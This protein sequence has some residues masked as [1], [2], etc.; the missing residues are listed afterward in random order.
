[1]RTSARICNRFLSFPCLPS[2]LQGKDGKAIRDTCFFIEAFLRTYRD[3]MQQFC[4]AENTLCRCVLIKE[5]WEFIMRTAGTNS[6]E[7]GC[8]NP[9][10]ALCGLQKENPLCRCGGADSVHF[11][12]RRTVPE[13]TLNRRLRTAP[14]LSAPSQRFRLHRPGLRERV[15][16]ALSIKTLDLPGFVPPGTSSGKQE[17]A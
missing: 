1:M 7:P 8:S 5:E 11:W 16:G 17:I 9:D 15:H 3:P 13:G 12:G 4:V 2:S 10:G 14:F 6:H